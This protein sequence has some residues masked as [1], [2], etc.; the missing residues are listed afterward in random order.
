MGLRICLWSQ[1]DSNPLRSLQD[2]A[3]HGVYSRSLGKTNPQNGFLYL[4]YIINMIYFY[5]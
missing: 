3:E 5:I 1:I 4:L 2:R